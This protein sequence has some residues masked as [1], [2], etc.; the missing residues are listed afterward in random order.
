MDWL[1]FSSPAAPELVPLAEAALLDC[2]P[3]EPELPEL[4]ADCEDEPPELEDDCDEELL[5]LEDE[6][7]LLELDDDF[8][9]ELLEESGMVDWVALELGVTLTLTEGCCEELGIEELW[10][11]ELLELLEDLEGGVGT[12]ADEGEVVGIVG[13]ELEESFFSLSSQLLTSTPSNTTSAKRRHCIDVVKD[14]RGMAVSRW[15]RR[16]W[17]YRQDECKV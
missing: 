17:R 10:L 3:A 7:E 1:P 4:E 6:L 9:P 8:E 12:D 13:A 11:E 16:L 15:R 14:E 2:V 5:E